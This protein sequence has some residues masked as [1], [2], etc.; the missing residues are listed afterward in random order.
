M[1][2]SGD[3]LVSINVSLPSIFDNNSWEIEILPMNYLSCDNNII[4]R[5][6]IK[7]SSN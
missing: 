2:N 3:L 7:I 1:L 4:I 5:E 6:S